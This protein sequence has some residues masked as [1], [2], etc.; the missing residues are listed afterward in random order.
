MEQTEMLNFPPVF[1][2]VFLTVAYS[3][4]SSQCAQL[5]VHV[6]FFGLFFFLHFL[7]IL[8]QCDLDLDGN[9]ISASVTAF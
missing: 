8:F 6:R 9:L 5:L 7:E 1:Q 2:M 3:F 4:T